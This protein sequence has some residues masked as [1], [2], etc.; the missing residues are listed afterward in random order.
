M[1]S[2]AHMGRV[3]DVTLGC[4]RAGGSAHASLEDVAVAA[5]LPAADLTA[6]FGDIKGLLAALV[7]PLLDQL[8]GVAR[9]AATADL[10]QEGEV[11]Q[12]ITAYIQAIVAHRALAG[13][14]LCEP[15]EEATAAAQR[16]RAANAALRDEL[17]G[18]AGAGLHCRIRA[19]SALA[20]AQWAVFDF[21][22][23]EPALLGAVL[24]D[25]AV[26]ILLS[27]QQQGPGR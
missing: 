3:R 1:D 11:R 5:G 12:V 7:E 19:S 2:E 4:V 25:A 27:G 16:L 26:A 14:L 17:A 18:G 21:P 24:T 23:I 20:A 8:G 22:E 10:A 6:R 9:L 15:P 13:V